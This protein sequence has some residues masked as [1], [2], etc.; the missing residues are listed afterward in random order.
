MDGG[1]QSPSGASLKLWLPFR[2]GQIYIEGYRQDN[3]PV[4]CTWPVAQ[5]RLGQRENQAAQQGTERS[6]PQIRRNY[7]FY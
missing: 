3:L 1:D 6:R 4:A 5:I 7:G 2:A